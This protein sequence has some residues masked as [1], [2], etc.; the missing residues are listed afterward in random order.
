MQLLKDRLSI[1]EAQLG[2]LMNKIEGKTVA[3][4]T[5]P[6]SVDDTIQP[7]LNR[8][9]ALSSQYNVTFRCFFAPEHGL[10]GR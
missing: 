4:L 2:E 8:I 1:I 9:I 3:M 7:L 10:R 5:F 6:T